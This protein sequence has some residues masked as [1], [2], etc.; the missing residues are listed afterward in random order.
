MHKIG[1][2]NSITLKAKVLVIEVLAM[3]LFFLLLLQSSIARAEFVVVPDDADDWAPAAA[4]VETRSETG[5]ETV[6]QQTEQQVDQQAYDKQQNTA[7]PVDVLGRDATP[8]GS[9]HM[10]AMHMPS[11]RGGA[12]QRQVSNWS[13]GHQA[14]QDAVPPPPPGPYKSTAMREYSKQ[15]HAPGHEMPAPVQHGPA[16]NGSGQKESAQIEAGRKFNPAQVPMDVYDPERPWPQN[17][18]PANP[19]APDYSQRPAAP[20]YRMR[21]NPAA[22]YNYPADRFYGYRSGPG[23]HAPDMPSHYMQAPKMQAPGMQ[24]P[25][26]WPNMNAPGLRWQPPIGSGSWS[27][28]AVYPQPEAPYSEQPYGY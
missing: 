22:M 10:P 8:R 17:I 5:R 4:A 2:L 18:R 19:W 16:K 3:C 14:M 26:N 15:G 1:R 28:G 7:E 20:Q 13:S 24:A 11:T 23:M 6:G 27:P 25:A 21:Q 9:M 12:M